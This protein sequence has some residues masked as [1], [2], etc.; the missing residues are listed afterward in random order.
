MQIRATDLYQAMDSCAQGITS[1]AKTSPSSVN[2]TFPRVTVP[3]FEVLGATT[4]ERSGLEMVLWTPIITSNAQ[5]QRW[6][7]Y[8][9]RQQKWIATSRALYIQRNPNTEVN[10]IAADIPDMIWERNDSNESLVVQ[11]TTADAPFMP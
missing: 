8:S 3:D 6:I 2:A 5:R 1:S 9:Q 4:L 7:G 11:P 10:Y